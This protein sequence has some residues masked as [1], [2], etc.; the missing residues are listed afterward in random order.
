MPMIDKP[1]AWCRVGMSELWDAVAIY[2]EFIEL[3]GVPDVEDCVPFTLPTNDEVEDAGCQVMC[4]I[5]YRSPI[6][7]CIIPISAGSFIEVD[8]STP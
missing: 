5:V 3:F 6:S 2:V 4:S 1:A 7:R 8:C